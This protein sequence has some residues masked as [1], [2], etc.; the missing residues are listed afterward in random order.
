MTDNELILILNGKIVTDDQLMDLMIPRV[1]D[2]LI[3]RGYVI[4]KPEETE[5]KPSPVKPDKPAVPK[6]TEADLLGKQ[7]DRSGDNLIY[8][9]LG[10]DVRYVKAD[11]KLWPKTTPTNTQSNAKGNWAVPANYVKPEGWY[12]FR[13]PTDGAYAIVPYPTEEPAPDWLSKD[14]PSRATESSIEITDWELDE[15]KQK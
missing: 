2:A 12:W 10:Q 8:E 9:G 4:K 1:V 5:T 15:T 6:I 14:E 13:S 3:S 11:G 7:V